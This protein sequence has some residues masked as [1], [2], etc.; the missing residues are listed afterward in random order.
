MDEQPDPDVSI[1]PGALVV[2]IDGT[3][4]ALRAVAWAAAE[5][6][7]RGTPLHILHAAPYAGD[8]PGRRRAGAILGHARTVA[9]HGGAEP[10]VRTV[11]SRQPAVPALAA[12]AQNADL[13]VLG[14]ITGDSVAEP[15]LGSLAPT[16]ASRARCPVV[17][18]RGGTLLRS[19]DDPVVVGV[20]SR[21]DDAAALT[22]AFADADRHGSDLVVVHTRHGTDAHAVPADLVDSL[23]PWRKAFPRVPVQYRV[24]AGTPTDALLDAA[25]A[26]RLVVLGA[27]RHGT[28]A[29]VLFGSTTRQLLRLSPAPVEIVR[30]TRPQAPVAAAAGGPGSRAGR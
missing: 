4:S 25:R 14:M 28:P 16:V 17:V 26:G 8:P 15:V 2:G 10:D 11:L 21:E 22:A 30:P 20:H 3:Q 6:R 29:R 24:G 19:P 7:L 18:V 5:A 13:L 23:A 27:H 9:R 12:A 1:E